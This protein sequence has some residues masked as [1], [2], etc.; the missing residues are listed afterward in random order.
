[1]TGH[2]KQ[3]C[4]LAGACCRQLCAA[5]HGRPLATHRCAGWAVAWKGQPRHQ[6]NA[7]RDNGRH[8]SRQL[9]RNFVEEQAQTSIAHAKTTR[10]SHIT[11]RTQQREFTDCRTP[12]LRLACSLLVLA[13]GER[14]S[15]AHA[16]A[17]TPDPSRHRGRNALTRT[18]MPSAVWVAPAVCCRDLAGSAAQCQWLQCQR[19]GGM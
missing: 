13:V 9:F 15:S 4:L 10:S 2:L 19:A 16:E 18:V 17:E 5:T 1:M 14:P 6:L 3:A 7:P 11:N 8:W 12:V